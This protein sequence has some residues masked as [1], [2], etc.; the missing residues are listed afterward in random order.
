[1]ERAA[2]TASS[3][4]AEQ[5]IEAQTR[6]ETASKQSNDPPL[7]RVNTLGSVEDRLRLKELM[8]LCTK[9]SDRVLDLETTKT[10]QAKENASLKKRVKKLKRKRKSKTPRMNLFKIGT[11][12][13]RSLGEEYASKQGRN[14]KQGKQSSI[15]EESDFDDEGFDADMDEVFKDVEGDAEQLAARIQAQEQEELTIEEKFKNFGWSSL[16]QQEEHL[17]DLEQK[18]KRRK[19]LNQVQRGSQIVYEEEDLQ[20]ESTKKQK[21]D[22]KEKKK[23]KQCFKIVPE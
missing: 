5:Y 9:L 11:S 17:Q 14:L 4:E 23:L 3:L 22:D 6:F 7:L 15:F 1:M 12:S 18:S 20:Q 13:R 10:A 21:M 2:T 16:E 8:N 19:P